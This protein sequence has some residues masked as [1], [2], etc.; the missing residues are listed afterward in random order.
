MDSG[1]HLIPLKIAVIGVIGVI[2]LE[3]AA[4]LLEEDE[5]QDGCSDLRRTHLS[6]VV[7]VHSTHYIS[8]QSQVRY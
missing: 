2:W 6:E 3:R 8:H 4:G 5:N 7:V 1:Q